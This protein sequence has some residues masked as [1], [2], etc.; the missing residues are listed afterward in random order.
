MLWS[1]S[2]SNGNKE[3]IL[4][5]L[6]IFLLNFMLSAIDIYNLPMLNFRNPSLISML[7][8]KTAKK[9]IQVQEVI[10]QS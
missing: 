5:L 6:T 8:T 9:K 7:K 2:I 10:F 3:D 1:S 4:H